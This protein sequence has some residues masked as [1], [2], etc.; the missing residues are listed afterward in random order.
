MRL[1]SIA[2]EYLD[3]QGLLAL[4]RES[5]L[6]KK[7][8]AGE[9]SGYKNHPQLQRFKDSSNAQEYIN[10]YLHNIYLE[11]LSRAY[12]FDHKK[13]SPLKK[14][15]KNIKVTN[16]Q[17]NYEFNHLLNKLKIRDIERFTRI[18]DLDRD[19]IKTNKIFEVVEGKIADW[20]IVK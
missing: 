8:L 13:I 7:V 2:P 10:I 20:E 18:K 9:T 4:W 16:G 5:L 11:A 6:A 14:N 19:K 3:R 15:L 12:S 1:W 17:V